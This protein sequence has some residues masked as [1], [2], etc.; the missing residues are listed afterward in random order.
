MRP[1]TSLTQTHS[2]VAGAALASGGGR[3]AYGG[4][5]AADLDAIRGE[6][7]GRRRGTRVVAVGTRG[8]V[9]HGQRGQRRRRG[10][11]GLRGRG[12]AGV[13]GNVCAHDT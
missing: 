6:D 11:R 2:T 8:R 10:Q 5:A 7:G 4:A 9:Y 12:G 1:P 13:R 3:G